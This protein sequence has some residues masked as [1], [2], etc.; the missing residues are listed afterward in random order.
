MSLNYLVMI[1]IVAIVIMLCVG[2]DVESYLPYDNGFE[3]P[4]N[5]PYMPVESSA[6]Q[7][8]MYSTIHSLPYGTTPIADQ[9]SVLKQKGYIEIP[10]DLNKI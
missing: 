7:S 6:L 5:G 10:Y 3:R 9:G 1:L 8:Q 4:L 2:G